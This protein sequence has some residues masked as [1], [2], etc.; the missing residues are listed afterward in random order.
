MAVLLL[1]EQKVSKQHI[2]KSLGTVHLHMNY[3]QLFSC[4]QV[5]NASWS[6]LA[7]SWHTTLLLEPGNPSYSYL[8]EHWLQ[9]C[10]SCALKVVWELRRICSYHLV[11]Q[12]LSFLTIAARNWIL[13]LQ[14]ELLDR[15]QSPKRSLGDTCHSHKPK[16]QRKFVR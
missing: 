10:G 14:E 3:I 15:C 6:W 9:K 5:Q 8:T 7:E 1:S 4:I 12:E 11:H 2:H 16:Q 13:R